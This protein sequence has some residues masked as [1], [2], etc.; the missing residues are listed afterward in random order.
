[1]Q[2][3]FKQMLCNIRARSGRPVA[4]PSSSVSFHSHEKAKKTCNRISEA[5]N[6]STDLSFKIFAERFVDSDQAPPPLFARAKA[7]MRRSRDCV[8]DK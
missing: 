6:L 8:S 2:G 5:S 3:K 1:M 7:S 4:E